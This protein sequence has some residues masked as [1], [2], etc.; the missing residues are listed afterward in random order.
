M[1]K[2]TLFLRK[3]IKTGQRA[4]SSTELRLSI[5]FHVW[6]P[7]SMQGFSLTC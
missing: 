6:M 5:G 4:L 2:R 1:R 7:P 3:P